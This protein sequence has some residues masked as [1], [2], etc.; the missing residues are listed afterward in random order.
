LTTISIS[1][2]VTSIGI[3]AFDYIT[4]NAPHNVTLNWGSNEYV[5]NY[6]YTNLTNNGY[7]SSY[8]YNVTYNPQ[9]PTTQ[10]TVAA[11]YIVTST[12]TD[13]K[14]NVVTA[15]SS[16]TASAR[17]DSTESATNSLNDHTHNKFLKETITAFS[18]KYKNCSHTV[19]ITHST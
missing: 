14:G 17:G 10:S 2:S 5:V 12:G 1:N 6:F 18:S 19:E 16:F 8:N 4:Y 9:Y 15:S 13:A 11:T 7:N 3:Y